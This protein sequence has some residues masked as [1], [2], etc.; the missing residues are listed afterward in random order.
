MHTDP[1]RGRRAIADRITRLVTSGRIAQP[2]LFVG[3]EGAGKEITALEIA[4]RVNCRTPET[5]R[6]PNWCESCLKARSFQHPD[7]RWVGP[8]P[9]AYEDSSQASKVRD[10]F[11]RKIVDPFYRPEFAATSQVLIGNPDHPGP[12]TIRGLMQSLRRQAFQARWKVAVVSDAHRMNVAAANAFLKTLEEPPPATLLVLVTSRPSSLLATIRSRCQSV[13]FE[14]YGEADLLE[15]VAA[16]AP[17]AEADERADAARLAGGDARRAMSLLEPETRALRSWAE[18]VF[19]A[20]S[21][22]EV[23]AGQLAADRLHSG[24]LPVRKDDGDLDLKSAQAREP[25]VRR[26]RAL[27]FCEALADLCGDAIACREC[28]SAWRARVVASAE[29]VRRIAN[30]RQTPSLSADLASIERAKHEIDGNLNLGL[31]MAVLCEDISDHVRTE[32]L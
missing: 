21:A 11:E 29:S 22:G 17:D 3:P 4:R 2:L 6:A 32:Q 24:V 30:A 10:L 23:G 16:L 18:T 31:V 12:L 25:T 14:P 8:A 5:C 26:H 7:I 19:G 28:G 20:L 1:H 27:V 15:L 13:V 9:A